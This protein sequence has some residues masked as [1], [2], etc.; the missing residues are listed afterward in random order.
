MKFVD[1]FSLESIISV[2]TT[3]TFIPEPE[4]FYLVLPRLGLVI[5]HAM[6]QIHSELRNEGRSPK[7]TLALIS[8]PTSIKILFKMLIEQNF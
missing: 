8:H 6:T 7:L 2:F 1:D 5:N 4:M 3:L